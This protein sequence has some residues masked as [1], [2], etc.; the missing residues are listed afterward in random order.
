MMTYLPKG[1]LAVSTITREIVINSRGSDHCPQEKVGETV[2]E[3]Q[4]HA[5]PGR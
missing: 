5:P 3:Y 1:Y 2:R 4:I